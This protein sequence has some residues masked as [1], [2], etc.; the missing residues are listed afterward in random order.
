MALRVH[1]NERVKPAIENEVRHFISRLSIIGP[2]LLMM[3]THVF[4]L[5][6]EP[7]IFEH[8]LISTRSVEFCASFSS[9]MNEVYFVKSTDRWGKGKLNSL[10]FPGFARHLIALQCNSKRGV[11][12]QRKTVHRRI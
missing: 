6:I 9:D 11:Y 7:E 10:D 1:P 3:C 2:L 12:E 5:E 4:S 8:G